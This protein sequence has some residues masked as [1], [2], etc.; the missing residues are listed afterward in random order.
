MIEIVIPQVGEAVAEVTLIEWLKSEG[1]QVRKGEPLFEV[2]TDK[3][4]VT[5]EAFADGLLAQILVPAGS[6]VMPRQ[7]VGLLAPADEVVAAPE[8]PTAACGKTSPVAQ[9]V[10]AELGV[11]PNAVSGSGPGGRVMA[12][13]V[14]HFATQQ[15]RKEMSS[16]KRV[17]ASP[18]A[19][20]VAKELGVDL[21]GLAGTGVDGLITVKDVQAVTESIQAA[22]SAPVD[23]QSPSK[24]RQAIATRMTVSKQTVPHFYLMADVDMAQA[25]QLRTYCRQTLGWERAPTYTDIIVQACALALAASPEVNVIYG[26]EG[27]IQRRTIDIGVAVSID[28][29]LIV[30]VLSQADGLSLRETSEQIRRLA[31]RAHQG[32][33]RE[34]DLS[35]KSMVVSNLGMYGVDAFIAIIDPPAPMILAVARVADRIVPVD[36]QPA[37][38]PMC[39]LSLSV[40]HRVLDGTQGS[41]F[42]TRVKTILENPFEMLSPRR[43]PS[44]QRAW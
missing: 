12:E 1:D 11:D 22:R 40:D 21:A 13:D 23:A 42:L 32:R 14:R 20:R 34:S 26:D 9:R 43:P 35:Q 6:G 24:L 37:I 31:E 25:Q 10:A 4:V 29:G 15:A 7:V 5:V 41:Q 8:E 36:G 27:L 2:D 38:R 19:R 18:K 28:N 16:P 44:E 30:P 39:T 17:L 33:L 3:T